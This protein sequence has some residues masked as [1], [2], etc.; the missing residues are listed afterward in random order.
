MR[1]SV[2]QGRLQGGRQ[3]LR[4]GAGQGQIRGVQS[5]GEVAQRGLRPR[6]DVDHQG[7]HAGI[8]QAKGKA[9]AYLDFTIL[10]TAEVNLPTW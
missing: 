4:I 3:A 10:K 5:R 1:A 7:W 9:V 8:A 2:A 6:G